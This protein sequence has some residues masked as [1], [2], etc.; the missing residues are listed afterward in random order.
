MSS[1]FFALLSRMK[2]INRWALMRNA[3]EENLSEHSLDVAIIS[4]ALVLLHNKR[5]SGS[6]NAER[7]AVLALF[8]DAPEILT[9]DMPTPV[10]YYNE[11]VRNAY[12]AVEENACLTILSMLPEDLKSEYTDFFFQ[13]SEDTELWKFVKAADKICA[14]I[15]CIEE[16]KAG[17]T[18]FNQAA[19]STLRSIREMNMPE[20]NCFIEE[21]LPD[22][23]KTLDELK[24]N[25]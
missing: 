4:H 18:E 23:E 8:H 16:K 9:G 19:V 3:H 11:Q 25:Y 6:L 13:S 5:F 15:K 1:S 20:A 12:R 7:A 22:F 14:L 17:N 24:N 2:Y 10:K 21:F